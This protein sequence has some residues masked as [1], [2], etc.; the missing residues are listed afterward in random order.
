LKGPH[1]TLFHFFDRF[2]AELRDITLFHE[3]LNKRGDRFDLAFGPRIPPEEVDGEASAL[4][5]R[6]KRYIERE[7]ARDPDTPFR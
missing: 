3:L 7:L 5:P 1:P 4:T 6:L 2:S